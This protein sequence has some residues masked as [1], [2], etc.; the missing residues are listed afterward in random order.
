MVSTVYTLVQQLPDLHPAFTVPRVLHVK[1][2]CM[3]VCHGR[4][5]SFLVRQ[6]GEKKRVGSG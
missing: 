5:G 1:Y 6:S 3:Y 4:M 2:V